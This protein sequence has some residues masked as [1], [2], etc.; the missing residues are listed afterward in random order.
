M[1]GRVMGQGSRVKENYYRLA[2]TSLNS[3]TA[4]AI[5]S[6]LMTCN[7]KAATHNQFFLE[8]S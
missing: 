8:V 1:K 7:A 5:A 2:I 4:L 3:Q 6:G